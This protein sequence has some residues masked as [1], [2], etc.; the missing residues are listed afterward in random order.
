MPD[1]RGKE[2]I[3]VVRLALH[4]WKFDDVTLKEKVIALYI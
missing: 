2:N 4:N 1:Y 3:A